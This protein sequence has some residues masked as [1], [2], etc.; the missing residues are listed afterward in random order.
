MDIGIERKQVAI[1]KILADSK[2]PLGEGLYPD[3]LKMKDSI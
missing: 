2:E 1:L 3:D